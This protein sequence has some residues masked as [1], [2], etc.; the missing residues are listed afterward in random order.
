MNFKKGD[1]IK[2]ND[3]AFHNV[4]YMF[5]SDVYKSIVAFH[6]QGDIKTDVMIEAVVGKYSDF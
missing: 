1:R 2:K 6:V 4:K 3:F 5:W